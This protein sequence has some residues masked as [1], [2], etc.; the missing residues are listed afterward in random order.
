MHLLRQLSNP[1]PELASLISE[2]N[3]EVQV[4]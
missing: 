2:S 3:D 1:S 4:L